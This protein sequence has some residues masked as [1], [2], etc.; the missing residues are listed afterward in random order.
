M[1]ST[2][3]PRAARRGDAVDARDAVVDG[4]E[5]SRRS[6]ARER[7][8]L[9]RQAVA[10]LEAVGHEEVDVAR[11]SRASPRTPTAQAVAPSAS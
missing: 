7:D 11:P 6:R 8:D 5:Q 3:M 2:S 9:G 4:D 10:V 1:I